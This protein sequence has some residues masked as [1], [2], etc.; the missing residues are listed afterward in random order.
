M[1]FKTGD[2]VMIKPL[3]KPGRV[4][5]S[6][7]QSRAVD[8]LYLVRYEVENGPNNRSESS[9]YFADELVRA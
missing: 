4:V 8:L 9:F 1:S 5:G 7:Q 3:G 6:Q 2:R